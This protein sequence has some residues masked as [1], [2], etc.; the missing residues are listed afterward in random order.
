[1]NALFDRARADRFAQLLDEAEGVRRRRAH[2]HARSHLDA[3]LAE[4]V[5]AGHALRD[6]PINVTP[7]PIFKRDLRAMLI[8]TAEREGIGDTAI[9]PEP[10][11]LRAVWSK[12]VGARPRRGRGA[13][14]IGIAAGTLA[15]SGVSVASGEAIPGDA[16]YGMK[17]STERAQLALAGSDLS[18]G[19]LYLDFA[20][21]RLNEAYALRSNEAGFTGALRDMDSETQDGVRM[22]IG[23]AM[24]RNDTTA[25]DAVDSFVDAQRTLVG[26][27]LS[28]STP[29]GRQKVTESLALLTQI[30][31]RA[32]AARSALACG[33]KPSGQDL[34]GPILG[35]CA[36]TS[37]GIPSG[38]TG[39]PAGQP[40]NGGQ[41]PVGPTGSG[42]TGSPTATNSPAATENQ[43]DDG[44]LGELGRIL[45]GL[46]GG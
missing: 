16:L 28:L 8:A 6:I 37:L 11:G 38:G 7:D 10:T 22:L 19:Q 27:M 35:G 24:T 18:R 2:S 1:M 33:A 23:F 40:T 34:L 15:L 41:A 9:H 39:Q 43:E 46:L 5:E 4:L 29:M 32:V 45:G 14:V 30:E 3:E 31:N 20:R 13:I 21:T 12:P 25:L 44:L 17:R 26:S 36:I 42:Q